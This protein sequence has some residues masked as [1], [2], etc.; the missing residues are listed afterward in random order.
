MKIMIFLR[1]VLTVFCAAPLFSI[2]PVSPALIF[3]A[4]FDI[5]D[6]LTAEGASMFRSSVTVINASTQTPYSLAVGT[7]AA[8][9]L[10]VTTTGYVGIGMTNPQEKLEIA[11]TVNASDYNLSGNGINAANG[12]VALDTSSR[13]P[14]VDGSQLTNL[15]AVAGNGSVGPVNLLSNG[16][17][18]IWSVGST[19]NNFLAG[20]SITASHT[21]GG[22]SPI[23][24]VDGNT[25]TYWVYNGS[26]GQYL[27]C[28]LGPGATKK[29]VKIGIYTASN[30]NDVKHWKLEGSTD[31]SSWTQLDAELAATSTG[32]QYWTFANTTA[33][34]YYRV[35]YLDGG[36][37]VNMF[38]EW[39]L[40]ENPA[41][42][43]PD[44]WAMNA[45]TIAREA[46]VIKSG[47]YSIKLPGTTGAIGQLYQ[48]VQNSY[49]MNY[50]QGR[51]VTFGAWVWCATA[52]TARVKL[53][54]GVSGMNS[55]D[56]PGD[57]QWHFLTVTYTVRSEASVVQVMCETYL[58]GATNVVAY[59][60]GATLVEG[61]SAFAYSPMPISDPVV[62]PGTGL[63]LKSNQ[64]INVII[65][66]TSYKL[67]LVQ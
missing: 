41:W 26:V 23:N 3:S 63:T 17:F 4:E 31:N 54:D 37:G 46:T 62:L 5:R 30:P 29:A 11:G 21:D 10:V 18:E 45:G 33:Y 7:G 28:D 36:S 14:A 27:T 13:L 12:I 19:Q 9:N 65:N 15:P 24:A 16:N 60:D 35:T 58:D 55:A 1:R 59:F 20:V 52:S 56:H 22:S 34:R 57:G 25:A 43:A 38:W 53:F 39:N 48:Q 44:G 47:A 42:S 2:L 66:G 40:F 8:Y 64:F 32:W 51:T 50:W 49:G 61:A 67:G 6:R